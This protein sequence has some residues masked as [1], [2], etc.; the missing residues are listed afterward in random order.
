M[1]GFYH[2]RRRDDL[3]LYATR[4]CAF[5]VPPDPSLT[6]RWIVVGLPNFISWYVCRAQIMIDSSDHVV[7]CCPMGRCSV[8]SRT[9]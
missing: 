4:L 6:L 7:M 8:S 3:W 5:P 9:K 2:G 1:V